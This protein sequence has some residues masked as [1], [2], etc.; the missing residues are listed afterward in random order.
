VAARSPARPLACVAMTGWN[1]VDESDVLRVLRQGSAVRLELCRPESLNALNDTLAIEL[2][3]AL[4]R[5]GSD[6]SVRC[7]VITGSGRGFSAGAD[8]KGGGRESDGD[9][10]ERTRRVL[11]EH[12]NPAILA[13]REMPK[14]VIAAVNGPAVGVGCSF[15]VACDLVVAAESAYFLLAFA[16][17]GLVGDGGATITIPA[18]VGMGGAAL[19]GLLAER[20]AAA[21]ALSWGLADRVVP[22]AELEATVTGLAMKLASG[23]TRAYAA[24][25]RALNTSCLAGLADQLELEAELQGEL[26]GSGDHQEGVAA[27]RD[28]RQPMFRGFE[29][30]QPASARS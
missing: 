4:L 28:K 24:T 8:I 21:D 1:V 23:P 22:D 12:I 18:R 27:F 25:K 3:D 29:P 10:G 30:R 14:P 6:H 11:R 2:R 7:L 26:A 19:L 20:L 17:I 16:N 5:L 9:R 15:A 13:I